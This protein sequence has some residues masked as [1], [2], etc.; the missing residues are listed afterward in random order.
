MGLHSLSTHTHSQ[1]KLN[2]FFVFENTYLFNIQIE[3]VG[4][5]AGA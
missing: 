1:G 3:N 5:V 4:G 2:V